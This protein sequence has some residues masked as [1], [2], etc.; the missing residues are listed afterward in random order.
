MTLDDLVK[1]YNE[2]FW[3]G[4]K[5]DSDTADHAGIRAVVMALRDDLCEYLEHYQACHEVWSHFD[6]ILGG[7]VETTKCEWTMDTHPDDGS[8]YE[9]ACGDAWCSVLGGTPKQDNYSFCPS[10][11]KPIVFKA[12]QGGTE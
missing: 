9:T 2:A 5:R 8:H 7:A 12:A 6:D 10:C 3:R 1:V 4:P 11:G